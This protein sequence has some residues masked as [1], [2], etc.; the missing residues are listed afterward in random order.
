MTN[1][2]KVNEV[3]NSAK[4]FYIVT[5]DGNKPKSRPVTFK[6]LEGDKLYFGLGTFKDS[7]KQLEANK[8]VEI[9]GCSGAKWIRYDGSAHFVL[10]DDD[11]E[12]RALNTM[13]AIK[14]IYTQ[15]GWK[16]GLFYLE[17]AHAEIKNVAETVDEFDL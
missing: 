12:E 9:I 1:I 8:N 17:N 11:L 5:V 6:M 16:L 3:L 14:K 2:E 4:L 15:N 7:F 10:D 13:P